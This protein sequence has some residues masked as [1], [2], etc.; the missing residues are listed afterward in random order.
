MPPCL[1]YLHVFSLVG[2]WNSA[3]LLLLL[4]LL[5]EISARGTPVVSAFHTA[6]LCAAGLGERRL[7]WVGGLAVFAWSRGGARG[8]STT[9]IGRAH[10]IKPGGCVYLLFLK[11]PWYL[12]SMMTPG[13]GISACSAA[14][15]S[16]P[17]E[18][19]SDYCGCGGE[20][21]CE[22]NVCA[23][24]YFWVDSVRVRCA[25]AGAQQTHERGRDRGG[26]RSAK[27]RQRNLLGRAGQGGLQAKSEALGIV[28][29]SRWT[30]HLD[31]YPALQSPRARGRVRKQRRAAE[32]GHNQRL[33]AVASAGSV[34]W[35][36]VMA[37]SCEESVEIKFSFS[38]G[39]SGERTRRSVGAAAPERF[40][41]GGL[42]SLHEVLLRSVLGCEQKRPGGNGSDVRGDRDY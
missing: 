19:W 12:W 36:Q 38:A 7:S 2:R 17:A 28:G 31:F 6:L 15:V 9:Q 8:S 20:G 4:A 27:R 24:I 34:G 40:G 10:R 35:L 29:R 23:E 37:A 13:M 11:R 14:I 41:D 3:D 30:S 33:V 39:S 22:G 5:V 26:M 21:G 1:I 32:H 16:H 42:V 18:L 25:Q